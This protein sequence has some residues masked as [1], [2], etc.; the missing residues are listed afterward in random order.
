[1]LGVRRIE[2][3]QSLA[4][5]LTSAGGMALAIATDVTQRDQVRRLV[6]TAV[7]ALGRVHV[8]LNNAGLMRQSPIGRRK[9]HEWDRMIDVNIKGV[10]SGIA[11][12]LPRM[13]KQTRSHIINMASVAGHKIGPGSAV[14]A[15]TKFAVRALSEG[16]RQ[17]H[18]HDRLRAGQMASAAG[19]KE[20]A[21]PS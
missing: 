21:V 18:V 4:N 12:A 15:A 2:R 1:M 19:P 13:Q 10:P 16:L 6:D 8:L 11:D 20:R 9:V 17:E 14:Y 7:E 3:L 5:E